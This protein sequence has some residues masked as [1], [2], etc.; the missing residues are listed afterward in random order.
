MV[1]NNEKSQTNWLIPNSVKE[2]FTDF[3]VKS[4]TIAQDDCAGALLIWQY[5]PAV[6]RE[7]A[8]L[9]AKGQGQIDKTFWDMFRAGLEI[10]LTQHNIRRQ[11][12][13]QSRIRKT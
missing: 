9:A 12:K 2:S 11:K 13:A 6:I 1:K 5:L 4:G 7:Q 10:G 3:C 8:K